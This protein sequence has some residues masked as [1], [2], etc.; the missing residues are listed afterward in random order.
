MKNL[1]ALREQIYTTQPNVAVL[2][3]QLA[4]LYL[5]STSPLASS[6]RCFKLITYQPSQGYHLDGFWGLA[7]AG[8]RQKG[9]WRSMAVESWV[10]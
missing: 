1:A 9:K 4:V 7:V 8:R 3:V 5:N 2:P 6:T 10:E